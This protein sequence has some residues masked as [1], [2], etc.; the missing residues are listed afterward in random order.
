M[1]SIHG[2]VCIREYMDY[3]SSFEMEWPHATITY[4][5][6][7]NLKSANDEKRVAFFTRI[8]DVIF[9]LS[10]SGADSLQHR[11]SWD[12]AAQLPAGL[13]SMGAASDHRLP[14]CFPSRSLLPVYLRNGSGCIILVFCH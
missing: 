1:I 8:L 3:I 7:E 9:V 10:V 14:L 5:S 4:N 13:H 11:F 2:S 12:Y 6:K